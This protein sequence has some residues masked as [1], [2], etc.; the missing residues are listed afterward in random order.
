MKKY[1]NLH[2]GFALRISHETR[3][4]KDQG[5]AAK[6]RMHQAYGAYIGA[7]AVKKAY[8]VL[9]KAKNKGYTA[10]HAE[11]LLLL[12]SSTKERLPHIEKF[13]SHVFSVTGDARRVLDLGCGF[14]PFS[15]PFFPCKIEEYRAIDVDLRVKALL[16]DCFALMNLPQ[17]AECMDLVTETPNGE[18]DIA[19]ML[20]LFPVLEACCPGRAYGLANQLD[21]AWLVVS[22]PT[23]SLG[24][25]KKGMRENYSK[26]F[27]GEVG[28]ICNFSLVS[29]EII[30]NELVFMLKRNR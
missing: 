18:T 17:L 20:K 4:A 11:R 7:N 2:P 15:L 10:E 5:K 21:A 28:N 1:A 3:G 29:E 25:R 30:G 12:H 9:A 16:D 27:R 26:A 22:Y 19:F 23:K 24:G 8:A 6:T 14:N 13:Y